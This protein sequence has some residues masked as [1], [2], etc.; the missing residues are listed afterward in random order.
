MY[1]PQIKQERPQVR[2]EGRAGFEPLRRR[3]LEAPGAARADAAMQHHARPVRPDL[4]Q[5]DPVIALERGLG[6]TRHIGG[7][8]RTALAFQY[9]QILKAGPFGKAGTITVRSTPL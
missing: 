1:G 2:P 7:A 5:F 6:S 9:V 8:V 4:G 3:G